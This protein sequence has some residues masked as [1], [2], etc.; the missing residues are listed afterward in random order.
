MSG[1]SVFRTDVPVRHETDDPQVVR[2][3]DHKIHRTSV[4]VLPGAC[5]VTGA[6]DEMIVTILGSCVAAC[7]R[8]P[9]TGFGGLNHF[10][11]P[12]RTTSGDDN[13]SAAMRYGSFA[14]E[15]LINKVLKSGC[16]REDLEIKLFGGANVTSGPTLIGEKNAEFALRYL[17]REGLKLSARD[18]GGTRGRRI[19][20]CPYSGTVRRR[21]QRSATLAQVVREEQDYCSSLRKRRP[22]NDVELFREEG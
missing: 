14:M 7:V 22:G 1:Q 2:S 20:F 3:F 6:K 15:M 12:E 9:H 5:Y 16:T 10:M 18:L 8:N 13:A 21:L 19:H 11:L 4:R 17:E